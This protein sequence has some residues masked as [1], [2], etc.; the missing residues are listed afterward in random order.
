MK[1]ASVALLQ[2]LMDST[3]SVYRESVLNETPVPES[4]RIYHGIRLAEIQAMA[5]IETADSLR[6]D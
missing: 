3:E 1:R 4:F 6:S 5:A 2:K